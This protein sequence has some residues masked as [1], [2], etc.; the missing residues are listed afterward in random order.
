MNC[1][2]ADSCDA[3]VQLRS[4]LQVYLPLESD[5]YQV[6]E[7]LWFYFSPGIGV[8]KYTNIRYI[9]VSMNW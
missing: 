3:F 2:I 8:L 4:H 9:H 7:K 1:T 5:R 6:Q